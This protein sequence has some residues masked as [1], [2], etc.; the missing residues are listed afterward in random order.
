[1]IA[2]PGMTEDEVAEQI[3]EAWATASYTKANCPPE[4][5]KVVFKELLRITQWQ[6]ER[7][8]S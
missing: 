3:R 2:V 6:R 5:F 7:K 1:M 4:E 8:A